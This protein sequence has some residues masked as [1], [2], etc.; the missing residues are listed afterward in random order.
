[1]GFIVNMCAESATRINTASGVGAGAARKRAGGSTETGTSVSPNKTFFSLGNTKHATAVV[2]ARQNAAPIA[3]VSGR[4]LPKCCS[5]FTRVLSLDPNA[6]EPAGGV[7]PP[8]GRQSRTALNEPNR[9]VSCAS[10]ASKAGRGGAGHQRRPLNPHA[11]ISERPQD[12]S[13][14]TARQRL[15]GRPFFGFSRRLQSSASRHYHSNPIR[16]HVRCA[17]VRRPSCLGLHQ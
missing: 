6:R 12:V 13:F 7:E 10:P 2:M 11:L 8:G 16:L 17:S 14:G 9:S 1:L 3:D 15:P 4:R 5:Q